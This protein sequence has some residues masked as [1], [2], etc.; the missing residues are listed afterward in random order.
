MGGKLCNTYNGL[1][2]GENFNISPFQKVI[3]HLS[4]LKIKYEQEGKISIVELM[5]LTMNSL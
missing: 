5:K 1:L 3:E 4:T 2:F